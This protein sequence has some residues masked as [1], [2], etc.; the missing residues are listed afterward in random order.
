VV[1]AA[2]VLL[3]AAGWVGGHAIALARV[4]ACWGGQ[5]GMPPRRAGVCMGAALSGVAATAAT[6][7]LAGLTA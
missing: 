2:L 1:V 3:M 5:P 6:V 7:A 4:S